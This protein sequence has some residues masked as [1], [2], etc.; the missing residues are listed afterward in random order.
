M[1]RLSL[2]RGLLAVLLLATFHAACTAA[3]EL[4]GVDGQLHAG[5]VVQAVDGNLVWVDEGG[6]QHTL[7]ADAWLRWNHPV[8]C[9][10]RPQL[11]FGG[12]SRVVAKRD[13]T[14]KVPATIDETRVTFASGLAGEIQLPR[15]EVDCLLIEAAKEPGMAR[16]LLAEAKTPARED[17]VWLVKG[18]ELRGRVVS[19]D[20]TTLQL[21]LA[22][23]SVPVLA[24]GIAG[25]GFASDQ[26][27][28]STAGAK[29]L[30]GLSDGS[31]FEATDLALDGKQ[32][33]VTLEPGVS[34][35]TSRVKSLRYL[36]SLAPSIVYLSDVEPVD[37]AQ[38]PYF[39][40]TWPLARDASLEGGPLTSAGQQ[41]AKGIAMHSAARAVYRVPEGA[42]RFCADIALDDSTGSRGSV[43]YRVYQLTA[44]GLEPA[45]ESPVVRGGEPPQ[46]VDVDVSGATAVVLVVD[47]ADRGDELDHANLLDAR[48]VR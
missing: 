48:F 21:E 33:E 43:V 5:R 18:D 13:W 36:Q 23:E 28:H 14:G 32:L 3:D 24:S 20:G 6:E 12:K 15:N 26:A 11:W 10:A 44:A 37:F 4:V 47:Y 30:V 45:Y 2:R 39:T 42:T 40:G 41:Y 8:A 7:A 17:R 16:R 38:T 1:H 29:F 35:S 19:F 34:L 25:V 27:P 9:A 22:G 46:S 31:L